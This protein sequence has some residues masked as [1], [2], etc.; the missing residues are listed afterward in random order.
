V[1]LLFTEEGRIALDSAGRQVLLTGPEG[2]FFHELTNEIYIADTGAERILVLDGD[3][4]FLKRLISRPG[5][6]TGV[7]NF[8]PS[9]IVVDNAGRI[10]T[11]VQAG[12]E[13]I[14]E[15]NPDG[16]FSRYFGI[17]KPVVNLLEHFWKLFATNEQRERMD[18]TFAPSF[19]NID[20]DGDGFVYATTYDLN[21]T[22]WVFRLNARGE[23]VLIN[24][25]DFIV[26]GDLLG[27]ISQFVDIAVNEYGVYAVLDRAN[28]RVFIYN[29]YG[30]LV[31]VINRPSGME[32]SFTAPTG[33]AWFGDYLVA[34]D[35]QLRRAYVYT[36]T[37]F[38]QLALGSARHY[39]NGEWEDSAR[40]LEEALRLNA[41]YDL[42]YSGI[43]KYYLMQGD[44]EN[45]MYYLKLGQN[46]EYYS[47]AFNHYRNEWVK[48]NF[49]WF[50]LLFVAVAGV[51]IFT[52]IKYHK[53]GVESDEASA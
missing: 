39:Y 37:E 47:Q 8:N 28:G 43:G 18:R 10:Y 22:A 2:V 45:A 31:S 7:T 9:K 53:K 48:R 11:V 29:F 3:R 25:D 16:S 19:N 34:T 50:A 24:P 40:L 46:R 30:E 13:G 49:V 52:E 5:D 41:N 36:M 6:M 42:A 14:V 17:N 15:L 32:G 27:E 12:F 26:V 23:N 21:A 38:G 35:R 44:Y 4:L 20:I 51:I 1:R 33:V